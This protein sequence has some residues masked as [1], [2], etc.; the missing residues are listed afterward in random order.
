MHASARWCVVLLLS[1]NSAVALDRPNILVLMAEDMSTRVHALGDPVAITPNLDKL[2]AQSVYYSAAFTTSGVCAPSRAAHITGMHAIA[3]GAQHM[4]TASAPAGA[5]KSVPPPEVKAYPELLRRAGYYTWTDQKLDYQFS[6][7]FA[8]SGPSTIW[9]EQGFAGHW[10]N[11][12][13]D[14]PF[15]GVMN[16][17]VTHESGL[18]AP[19]GHWPNS[20][21]HFL[22]QL[23]RVAQT[24]S[25]PDVDLI[26]PAD[27]FVPP[28]LADTPTVRQDIARHYNNITMMDWQVGQILSELDADDLLESTIVVWTTDHGDGL[29][30][31]KRELYDSGIHVPLLVRWP[32]QWRPE[33]LPAGSVDARLVSFVDIAPTLLGMAGVPVPDYIQ[34]R[35]FVTGA[36]RSYVYAARDRIDEVP[37]RQRAV[38]DT[39]YKLI[40][41][42]YPELPGGHPLGFR[43][44][45]ASVRELRRMHAEGRLNNEQ[46]LWFESPG[47]YRLY[48]TVKDPF[49]LRNLAGDPTLASVQE[50]LAQALNTWLEDTGDT[51]STAEQDM[52]AEFWPEGRAPVTSK[53]K[54]YLQGGALHMQGVAGASIGY[55]VDAG[56]WRVYVAPLSLPGGVEVE[57]IAVRYGWEES[58]PVVFSVPPQRTP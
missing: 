5:Y 19:L 28:Y 2:A 44:N 31:G 56:P 17:N 23:L 57:A 16:F 55:R 24:W 26:T 32:E 7:P 8:G 54:L 20:P 18:F 35:D 1:L 25:V 45:L 51:A 11:R 4:R 43:D 33:N 22:M 6:G 58:G 37:D 10:R 52:I 40:R 34:G 21:T 41:S 14:Q 47:D 27:V 36:P 12:Q 48:D 39:R 42:W 30:R 15:F 29:P 49:E 3:F 46:R 13:S 38:R 50:R 9:D 53:P